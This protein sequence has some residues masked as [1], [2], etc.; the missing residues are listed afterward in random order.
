VEEN[1]WA[2]NIRIV[3]VRPEDKALFRAARNAF[4]YAQ[5]R[6]RIEDGRLVATRDVE[7]RYL[8]LD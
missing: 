8:P 6:P 2:E 4:W 5:F 1:G 3:E 7:A